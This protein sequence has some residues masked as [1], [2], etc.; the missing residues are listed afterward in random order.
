MFIVT[1]IWPSQ[2]HDPVSA[3]KDSLSKLNLDYVDLY[4]IHWP[5]HFFTDSKVPL[6]VL[7]GQLESLVD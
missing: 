5:A 2:F 6:H 3:I 1:K 7:W 4:L